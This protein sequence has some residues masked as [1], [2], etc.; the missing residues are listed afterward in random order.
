MLSYQQTAAPTSLWPEPMEH[1][2][3]MQPGIWWEV[4]PR[5]K[6]QDITLSDRAFIGAVVNLPR[7]LRPWGIITWLSSVYRTSRETLYT[8]GAQVRQALLFSGQ[9]ARRQ[10]QPLLLPALYP[11]EW[12]T[13]A[14]SDNRLKRTILTFLLPGVSRYVRCR[15]VVMWH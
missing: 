8:I 3:Q 5:W 12:P 4:N 9:G 1:I 6:R 7:A 11:P 10:E 15:T 2:W 13:V 14:V